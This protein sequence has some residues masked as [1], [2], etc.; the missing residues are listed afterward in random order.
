MAQIPLSACCSRSWLY[1]L[2]FLLLLNTGACNVA[3]SG[4]EI[5]EEEDVETVAD[6]VSVAVHETPSGLREA[7]RLGHRMPFSDFQT[8]G[9]HL[10]SD[11]LL[12]I[13]LRFEPAGSGNVQLLVGTYSRYQAQWNPTIFN[14]REGTQTIWPA[15]HNGG[16]LYIRFH[17]ED[18]AEPAGIAHLTFEAGHRIAPHYV[19]G[20]TTSAQWSDMLDTHT[21]VPDVILE[22]E[23]GF[24]VASRARALQHRQENIDLLLHTL[25]DIIRIEAEIS[26]LDGSSSEHEPNAHKLLLTESNH[27]QLYMAATW[28]RTMFHSGTMD[29]I[30]TVQGLRQNGWGPWHEVGHMYQQDAWTWDTTVETTVNIYSLA[31][32]RAF[33]ITPSRLARDG[34]WAR[35]DAYFA[36][37]EQERDYNGSASDVWIRLAMYQQLWLSYGDAF[38]HELH[39]ATREQQPALSS[40]KEKM[41][42]LMIASS[43]IAGHDLSDFF[44]LWGFKVNESV[45]DELAS[46]G[47]PEPPV[48]PATLSDDPHFTFEYFDSQS[49]SGSIF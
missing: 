11:A 14:L 4:D 47:L 48:N 19:L 28:Y 10:P 21:E 1:V 8:T 22:S 29:R 38:Y 20:E 43:T 26:G 34:V 3:G 40:R 35:V 41:R 18:E 2:L 15:A 16:L 17:A 23:R 32:E 36:L 49:L 7:E 42:Y 24:I 25:D 5:E 37:G 30:L 9:L 12:E 13:T 27:N 46:L 39:R 45:Y 6:P 31:V 44:R 33:G